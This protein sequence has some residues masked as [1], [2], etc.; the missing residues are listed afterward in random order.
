MPAWCSAMTRKQKQALLS[1]LGAYDGPL[2]GIWGDKSRQ[3]TI[4][5]QRAYM[6]TVDGIFREATEKR[7]LEVVASGEKPRVQ[8]AAASD[9]WQAVKYFSRWEFRCPCGRCGGFPVEPEERLVRLADMVRQHF[10]AP[11]TVSS[12]VRCQAHNDELPGSVKNSYHLRGK[13][14][15]FCVRGVSGATLLA[16]VRQLPGVHYAY[17]IDDSFVHMD[18]A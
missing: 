18:V 4:D 16:Y 7:I 14:M 1:Y 2:D 13:A 9:W 5:F 17:Q 12:G 15:D 11:A 10:D 3:A 8:I 6:D